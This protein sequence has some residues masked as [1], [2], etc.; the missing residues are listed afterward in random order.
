MHVRDAVKGENEM[1]IGTMVDY[2][3]RYVVFNERV[4]G[5][6]IGHRGGGRVEVRVGVVG[7][8]TAVCVAV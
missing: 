3:L 7:I 5:T 6:G 2:H 8:T 4:G 1:A